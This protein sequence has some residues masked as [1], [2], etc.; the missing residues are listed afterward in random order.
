MKKILILFLYIPCI[1][2]YSIER[3]EN[4]NRLQQKYPA[5]V[6]WHQF[7]KEN[8]ESYTQKEVL[9]FLFSAVTS[10]GPLIVV[11]KI[12]D[13]KEVGPN[14]R[15]TNG[16]LLLVHAILAQN[17]PA[18]VALIHR[19]ARLI[20]E[21]DRPCYS[22]DY[23][24]YAHTLTPW[25]AACIIG[26]EK[27]LRLVYEKMEPQDRQWIIKQPMYR[28][29]KKFPLDYALINNKQELAQFVCSRNKYLITE[30]YDFERAYN[31][32][33]WHDATYLQ[34][35]HERI[36]N[37]LFAENNKEKLLFKTVCAN[38]C[39]GAAFLIS[40][41]AR[42]DRHMCAE[43]ALQENKKMF[44]LI[45]TVNNLKGTACDEFD[46]PSEGSIGLCLREVSRMR[47]T[48]PI[49][50][51]L[52]AGANPHEHHAA[53]QR[54]PI[55]CIAF[56]HSNLP[57]A[58]SL[59]QL[60]RS[61]GI[62]LNTPDHNGKTLL[63]HMYVASYAQIHHH[64]KFMFYLLDLGADP[65]IKNQDGQTPFLLFC[66]HNHKPK[67]LKKYLNYYQPDLNT[68]DRY[69][70]TPLIHAAN[71]GKKATTLITLLRSAGAD[72]A[73]SVNTMLHRAC[74]TLNIRLAQ[75]LLKIDHAEVNHI[76]QGGKTTLINV[77]NASDFAQDRAKLELID[78]LIAHG[79]KIDAQDDMGNTALHYADTPEIVKKLLEHGASTLLA[80]KQKQT[81][82]EQAL[83]SNNRNT[84]TIS[85][86]L[87]HTKQRPIYLSTGQ[88][89]VEYVLAKCKA[90]YNRTAN[91][92]L[93]EM[94]AGQAAETSSV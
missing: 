78:L 20:F 80:N 89:I 51:L 16:T 52:E 15:D 75:E 90:H 43:A 32:A 57:L 87:A 64:N 26:K 3:S 53:D 37:M 44:D 12:L 45:A 54:Q 41:G 28:L 66:A 69:G 40:H 59:V 7:E 61:K 67:K 39:S 14:V 50:W 81:A 38:N 82:L 19:N 56:A 65:N 25:Q 6:D 86:L 4:P 36:G 83:N 35:L 58:K 71:Q 62:P 70:N 91:S 84:D 8:L 29:E 72:I 74:S 17:T 13:E 33:G 85:L 73:P 23:D 30:G 34:M 27:Y 2:I 47:S 31:A 5:P 93:L 55:H 77:V 24:D 92:Q 21:M 11:K 63:H 10:C 49:E 68:Q 94:V 46:Y 60:F 9:P 48:K 22:G 42:P 18:V 88:T 79:A 1:S 76:T